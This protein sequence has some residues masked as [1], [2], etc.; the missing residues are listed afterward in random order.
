MSKVRPRVEDSPAAVK[1]TA[2]TSRPLPP[3]LLLPPP[4]RPAGR[5]HAGG[6]HQPVRVQ[7][8]QEEVDTH[9]SAKAAFMKVGLALGAAV[10]AFFVINRLQES[11]PREAQAVVSDT[12]PAMNLP[13]L[14]AMPRPDNG[15]P[16]RL[17]DE[18][19][20]F[21]KSL[22]AR[23]QSPQGALPTESEMSRLEDI[24]ARS[25]ND[26][27]VRAFLVGT[28]LLQGDRALQ[29]GSYASLDQA[30]SK[31][32]DL[33]DSQ[34]QVYELETYG[35]ARQGDWAAAEAAARKY[36]SLA[37]EKLGISMALAASLHGL[38]RKPEA[39]A[40]LDRQVFS[41]C[42][43][44]ASPSDVAACRSAQQLRAALAAPAEAAKE[45]GRTREALNVDA[46]KVQIQSEKFDIRFDGDSQS[47]VARDVLFVL[48]R[49][50]VRLADIYYDR[51]DRKI[52]VVLHSSQ[53]YYTATGAPW[54]SGG[55]FSSHNGAIQI[56]IQGLPS[57]LPRQMEDVLVH[58]LSHAFVDEMSGGLAGSDLQEGLAQYMEGK[59]IE[60]ELGP[61]ELK[62]LANSGQKNVLSFYMLSLAVTQQLVQSRGQGMINQLLKAMKE[63]GSEDEGFKKVFGQPG[64]AIKRDILE[65]FWR[66]YS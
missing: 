15:R 53:S 55:Q 51:P 8:V 31:L 30:V 27:Q 18:D 38:G 61:A 3:P 32:K 50:Y 59:R 64:T 28:Y 36:D 24:F 56:P 58:E 65:T 22:S 34:P 29:S 39:L 42:S 63:T 49:A 45:P 62:R 5:T 40:V 11:P 14:P 46:S 54:W 21:L 12:G 2:G 26:P 47:G 20:G 4:S 41:T 33:D 7:E 48:D 57:T 35:K 16:S 1:A 25:D 60:Q 9:T 66:R 23:L 37:G 13:A 44:A 6:S 52:P 19:W 17:T 10:A 43:S